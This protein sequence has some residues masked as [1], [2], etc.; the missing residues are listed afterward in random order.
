M[1]SKSKVYILVLLTF[2]FGIFVCSILLYAA[3]QR[4]KVIDKYEIANEEF[5]IRV[6]AYQEHSSYALPGARY[7]FQ[8]AAVASEDWHEILIYKTDQPIPI[9]RNQIRFVHDRVAYIFVGNYY[10]V[11]TDSGRTW[12][13]WDANKELP[14]EEFMQRYNLWPAVKEINMQ[15]DG[16]GRMTLHQYITKSE[17]GPDLYTSDYGHHW[18]LDERR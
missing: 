18:I 5:R 10:A 9:P 7:V 14:V 8:S 4:P 2:V 13:V 12:F 3:S 17:R 1:K 15:S 11:T 16:T 6:T